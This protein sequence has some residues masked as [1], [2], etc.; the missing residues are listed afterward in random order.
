MV[1]AGL[2]LLS[3]YSY[4]LF[5]SLAELFSVVIAAM[6]FVMAWNSRRFLRE[7]YLL[8]L[9][10]ALIYVA[11]LDLLHTLTYEGMGVFP[12]TTSNL[13]TQ[14][15]IAARSLQAL[16]FLIVPF[17][18][19]RSI[20]TRLVFAVY[21]L[22]LSLILFSIFVWKIFP[23][24][25][26]EGIGLTPFK[27]FAE[28]G[29]AASFLVSM[30]LLFRSEASLD[31]DVLH[32]LVLSLF[33][34][35][36]SE[37]AFTEYASVYDFS[38]LIG[39]FF[40]ILAFYLIYR[41]I[42]VTGMIKPY[43]LLFRDLKQR[44]VE[45]Q[46]AHDE[47]E[48]RVQERTRQIIEANRA[49][50]AEIAEHM[51]TEAELEAVRGHLEEM[52]KARTS[53]LEREIAER[54]RAEAQA[55]GYAHQL[56]RSN[57]ELEDFASI[58]SHDLQEPLRKVQ[59]FGERLAAQ[60]KPR[61]EPEE[62]LYL[63]RMQDAALRMRR[64]I[65][66]LL[67]FA[68]V[69]SKSQ[70][71]EP[72]DL[73]QVAAEVVSD[74]EVRVEQTNG[75]IEI[76]NLPWVEADPLQM[77]QLFQN[78]IGNALKFHRPD[79]SPWVQVYP[80]VTDYDNQ[81]RTNLV[82]VVVEDNGIGFDEEFADQIFKPFRRLVGRSAYEGSGM[83]LAICQ[84]IVERHGGK[85]TAHSQPGRGTKFILSLPAVKTEKLVE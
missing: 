47:L 72:V 36:V 59:V 46:Q 80:L 5:H 1:L 55:R 39:H 9:G 35:I 43:N 29:I 85:I 31:R 71:S 20:N 74:L 64:M 21:T 57:R 44:E 4:L 63:E 60:A 37:L 58:A 79:E 11:F 15:W 32:L 61:L 51:R 78:L 10:I 45:L 12:G 13:A 41:A 68:R 48:L 34:S 24:C 18:L 70:P 77:R 28:Y 66:D 69:T 30:L 23:V 52:V 14:L 2:Y 67:T 16:S 42:V 83:G 25:Y 75:M 6:V 54:R 56:E 81:D 33:F 38:N 73:N 3:L 76:T 62:V 26:I 84:K 50:Q 17:F 19:R 82:Q 53:D 8:F 65:N 22:L 40:K 27:R 7:G 49:L